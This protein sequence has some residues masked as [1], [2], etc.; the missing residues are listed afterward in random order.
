MDST[1]FDRLDPR[2]LGLALGVTWGVAVVVL[3][4]ASR[5]GW[6]TRWRELLSDAYLGYDETALGLAI[7]LGWGFLDGLIGGEVLGRL[8]NRFACD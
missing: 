4:L 3:G 2:A 6:G 8:Y 1:D 5:A 7:G